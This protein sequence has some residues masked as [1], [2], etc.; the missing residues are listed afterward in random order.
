M[1]RFT[2]YATLQNTAVVP[3]AIGWSMELC[4]YVNKTYKVNLKAGMEMFG[5][6]NIHWEVEID[7]LDKLAEINAK[8]ISDKAYL[9]MIE[10]GKEF[11]ISGSLKDQIVNF[12]QP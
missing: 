5:G 9:S 1:Y 7:S 8:L 10:K 4:G 12:P 3:Q 6:L 2:R 11:W